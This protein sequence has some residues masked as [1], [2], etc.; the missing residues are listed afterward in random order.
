MKRRAAGVCYRLDP[1]GDPE[2]ALVHLKC[3][4]AWTFPKGE[5]EKKRDHG[6]PVCAAL[7]EACEEAGAVKRSDPEFLI[8]YTYSPP[9]KHKHR[10]VEAFLFAASLDREPEHPW[11]T[12]TWFSVADARNA[13]ALGR[14][15]EEQEQHHRVLDAAVARL[16]E[17]RSRRD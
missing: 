15:D 12:P 17:R 11:R 6:D 5:V 2:F 13:L 16:A 1:D 9:N 4:D 14:A 7:R 10:P 8:E 3:F